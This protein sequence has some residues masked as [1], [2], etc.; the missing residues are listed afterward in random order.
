MLT[1]FSR[2]IVNKYFFLCVQARL[3]GYRDLQKSGKELHNEQLQ[4]VAKYDEVVQT[5]EFSRDLYKQFL[6]IST[7][8]SKQQKKQARKE[9]L[10]KTQQEIAKFKEILII[11][12]NTCN[13][14]TCEGHRTGKLY[15]KL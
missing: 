15:K 2:Q 3:D 9:A 7:E 12:V 6:S 5:L 14:I 13:T 11:Q 8:T 1:I 10:E 4:A